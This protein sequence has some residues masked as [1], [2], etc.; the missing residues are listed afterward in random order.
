MLYMSKAF[1]NSSLCN[2]C[3]GCCIGT[4]ANLETSN[5]EEPS[6]ISSTSEQAPLIKGTL[7]G[8]SEPWLGPVGLGH[9]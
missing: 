2:C 1:M 7:L 3:Q 5:P 6:L 8:G 4:S 9:I